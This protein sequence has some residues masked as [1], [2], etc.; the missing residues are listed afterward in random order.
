MKTCDTGRLSAAEEEQVVR[1]GFQALEDAGLVTVEY[2]VRARIDLL[3]ERLRKRDVDILHFIGHGEYREKEKEA[4]LVFEN[5]DGGMYAASADSLRQV[6][7]QRGIRLMFLNACETGT[8]GRGE[9]P[10]DFNRG[11]APKLVAGGIP[12]LVANQYKVLDVSATEFAKRFYW[13]LARGSTVGDAAR[14]HAWL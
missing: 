5:E 3:H 2:I 13:W 9:N 4:Y 12:F 7:C 8:V 1:R 10:I 11:V 6:L 14:E